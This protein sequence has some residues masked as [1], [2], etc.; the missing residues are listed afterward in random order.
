M[1]VEVYYH[2]KKTY[3]GEFIDIADSRTAIVKSLD[4]GFLH[5]ENVNSLKV[6]DDKKFTSDDKDELNKKKAV[7]EYCYDH[8]D[9]MWAANIIGVLLDCDFRDAPEVAAMFLKEHKE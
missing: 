3:E 6:I 2:G 7:I 4:T 9:K 8:V 1:K 5:A